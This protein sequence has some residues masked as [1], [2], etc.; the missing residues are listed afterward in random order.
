MT[1][2]KFSDRLYEINTLKIILNFNHTGNLPIT[3]SSWFYWVSFLRHPPTL[4]SPSPSR[5]Q[6]YWSS[7]VAS[8]LTCKLPYGHSYINFQCPQLTGILL[9]LPLTSP[10]LSSIPSASQDCR[11]FG[12]WRWTWC[13][14]YLLSGS[15]ELQV[16]S[17][18]GWDPAISVCFCQ[19][20][21]L[22][23]VAPP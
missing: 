4:I 10:F 13:N 19:I 22:S 20:M 1:T 7:P 9:M 21:V 2:L 5:C 11:I 16:Y 14:C 12:Y 6:S 17:R 3:S 8:H 15:M 18:Y 23:Q